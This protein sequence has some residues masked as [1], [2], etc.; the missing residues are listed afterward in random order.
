LDVHIA[1]RKLAIDVIV[2][3]WGGGGEDLVVKYG[4]N[5]KNLPFI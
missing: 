5:V 1:N 3:Y 4:G 2:I